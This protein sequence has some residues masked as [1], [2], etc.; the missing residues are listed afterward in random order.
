[1]PKSTE[2]IVIREN[3]LR[4]NINSQGLL[5]QSGARDKLISANLAGR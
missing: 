4:G 5:D 3:D 1:M 2:H